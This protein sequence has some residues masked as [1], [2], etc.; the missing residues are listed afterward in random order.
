MVTDV[1]VNNFEDEVLKSE[2]PV[3]ADFWAPWCG[4]CKMQAPV[5]DKLSEDFEGKVKF[6]K[7][8]TDDNQSLAID[9]GI[10]GIPTLIIYKDGGVHEKLVGL[11][12]EDQL[13]T[14]L[15]SL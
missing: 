4:P 13:S 9:Y 2:V 11:Q 10:T 8:N 1:N 3:V 15:N 14:K 12:T 6:V 7:V 5:I